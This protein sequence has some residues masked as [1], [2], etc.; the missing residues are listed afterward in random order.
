M[1]EDQEVFFFSCVCQK[2]KS[3]PCRKAACTK[4]M[5]C[6]QKA[7]ARV[8]CCARCMPFAFHGNKLQP[9][10]PQTGRGRGRER[11]AGGFRHKCHPAQMLPC[12]QAS[13]CL[14][15]LFSHACKEEGMQQE[16][17][18][19]PAVVACLLTFC[20]ASSLP[21]SHSHFSQHC[22]A[23][24]QTSQKCHVPSHPELTFTESQVW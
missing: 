21:L 1:R 16:R 6:A 15:L 7:G 23:Q 14:F 12:C 3:M 9:K 18:R 10:G 13:P 4:I 17:C 8:C 11:E 20:P 2:P 5:S 22:L 19:Q 24:P